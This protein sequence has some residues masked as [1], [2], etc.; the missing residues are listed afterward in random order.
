MGHLRAITSTPNP[1][2]FFPDRCRKAK[3][4]VTDQIQGEQGPA[5]LAHLGR[6]LPA[7]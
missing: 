7:L 3:E 6:R 1:T 5:E 4:N 2:S